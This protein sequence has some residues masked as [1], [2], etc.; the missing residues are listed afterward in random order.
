M[1]REVGGVDSQV[2]S[3]LDARRGCRL[4][5]AADGFLTPGSGLVRCTSSVLIRV[6]VDITLRADKNG[7]EKLHAEAPAADTPALPAARG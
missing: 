2:R 5:C 3:I 1:R 6:A 7:A 4:S